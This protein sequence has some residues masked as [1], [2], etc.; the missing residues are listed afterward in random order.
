MN[1]HGAEYWSARELQPLLGYTQWRRF[2]DAITRAMTS[3]EAS[4]NKVDYHFAGAGKPIPGG[5]GAV[6]LVDDFHLSRFACYLIAQN[7]DPRK[8]E[9]ANAQ[10]YF[11]IQ[12]RRQELSDQLAADLERL[13][14]R[15]QAGEDFKALSGAAKQAGVQ[16]RMFGVFHDAGY[17]GLY[18]G[19]G[20]AAIK[21]VK[22]V[23]DKEQL[24]DRMNATELAANQ[25]RMTQTREKLARDKV[26]DQGRAIQTH[27]DVGREVR[28]AI[29]SIGGT[30]PERIS[31]AEPIRQ[32]EKRVKAATP[33]L[34]LESRDAVGLLG[35]AGK[36]GPDG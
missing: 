29:E 22:G 1:E 21:A 12:T 4:G 8:P 35:G 30:P 23:G 31:A 17:K 5:K 28:K 18:G 10:K 14:L 24:M 9:I 27:E 34:A 20:V 19:R 3:C 15:K 36:D 11:A 33:K 32:V 2:A 25:F 16:D 13:E 26:R 6:Q 7:G